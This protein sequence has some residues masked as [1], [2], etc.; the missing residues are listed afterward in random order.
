MR[1]IKINNQKRKKTALNLIGKFNAPG[2]GKL[3]DSAS[4]RIEQ[5]PNSKAKGRE[6]A[7][8][9]KVS[10]SKSEKESESVDLKVL[11]ALFFF[12]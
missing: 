10:T 3:Q 4:V 2:E 7:R 1:L 11:V 5:R 9:T 8:Y 6:K 12:V